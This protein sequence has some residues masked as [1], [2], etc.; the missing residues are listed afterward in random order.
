MSSEAFNPV[1]VAAFVAG[2][3]LALSQFRLGLT[4]E[5]SPVDSVTH[6]VR[7]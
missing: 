2:P 4:H 3:Q 5:P 7:S 6:A 1:A